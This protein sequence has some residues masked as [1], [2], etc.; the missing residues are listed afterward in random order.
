MTV[1]PELAHQ[2][3]AMLA[4]MLAADL[5]VPGALPAVGAAGFGGPA[6]ETHHLLGELADMLGQGLFLWAHKRI[7][8]GSV[9]HSWSCDQ[10][11]PPSGQKP[12]CPGQSNWSARTCAAMNCMRSQAT[13]IWANH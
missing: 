11:P 2:L 5:Q 12:C 7:L 3:G 13:F 10:R 8:R 6:I 1:L 9:S 4:G